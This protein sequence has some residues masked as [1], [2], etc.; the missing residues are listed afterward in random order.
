[1][2]MLLTTGEQVSTSTLL[3]MA[4]K[5]LGQKLFLLLGALAGV[6]TNSVHTKGKIKDI[7]PKRILK[8]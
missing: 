1:M 8:N 7:Q 2:D 4:F 5:A 6:K 3:T